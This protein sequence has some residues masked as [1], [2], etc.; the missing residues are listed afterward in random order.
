MRSRAMGFTAVM[1]ASALVLSAC[2]ADGDDADGELV[3]WHMETPPN[4][5]EALNSLAEEYN[6]GDPETPVRFEVQEWDEIYA[7]I[8]AAASAGS[9]PDALFVTP[10]LATYVRQLGVG[11]PVTDV[12][13]GMEAE[14]GFIDAATN[15]YRDEEEYWAVPLFGM[16]QVLWYR[17]DMFDEAGLEAP[18]TWEDLLEAAETLDTDEHSGIALPAGQNQATDQVVYS[19]MV[20]NGAADIF[21]EEGEIAFDT[22]ATVDTFELYDELLQY[23]PADSGSYA[24]GEPQA[25]FN[26]G[27][28]AINIEKGQYLTPFEEETGLEPSDLGCAPIPTPESGGQ[29][30]SVYYSNG[31]MVLS[32]SEDRAEDTNDFL[33]WLLDT[34]NYGDLLNAEPGLYLPLT[35][36]GADESDWREHETISTY[37]ECVD[38]MLEQSESGEL[39]GFVDGQYIDDVGEIA[40]Q[41]FIARAVQ[42]T[43]VNDVPP[44]EAVSAAQEQMQA[45]D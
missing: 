32:E 43:Y 40:S 34:E 19:L 12:V 6:S 45:A 7:T 30:G 1:A 36:N 39:F 3:I 37:E 8:A 29:P 38:L 2:G 10:D 33:E 41:N 20:T 23:S 21:T 13:E 18:Q 22:P 5:V 24:W 42:E 9:Q 44:A 25:A 16:V 28:A 26:S 35:E 4:R 15:P 27:S 14:H 31:A 11:S 17:G